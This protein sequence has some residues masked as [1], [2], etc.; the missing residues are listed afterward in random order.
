MY[1]R[2]RTSEIKQVWNDRIEEV[3]SNPEQ[4]REAAM[5]YWLVT[6]HLKVCQHKKTC[7]ERSL[8]EE[9]TMC[10]GHADKEINRVKRIERGEND[11]E[12]SN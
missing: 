5:L 7:P 12:G 8:L 2:D 4:L 10:V 9:A 3:I 1:S 11:K 6:S